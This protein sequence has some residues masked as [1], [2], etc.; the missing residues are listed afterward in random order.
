MELEAYKGHRQGVK[1]FPGE[2]PGLEPQ[3]R[4]LPGLVDRQ[5]GGIQQSPKEGREQLQRV[6]FRCRGRESS[7]TDALGGGVRDAETTQ[8]SEGLCGDAAAPGPGHP[9]ALLLGLCGGHRSET[10]LPLRTPSP[11]DNSREAVRGFTC[12]V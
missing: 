4:S 2:Q 3:P 12:A 9:T 10:L 1:A 11:A 7:C 5:G 6:S 8:G